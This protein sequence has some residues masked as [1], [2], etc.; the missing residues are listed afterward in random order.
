MDAV[1]R[2]QWEIAELEALVE[3]YRGASDEETLRALKLARIQIQHRRD[4]LAS[5][6]DVPAMPATASVS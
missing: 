1:T 2:L 5:W 4:K 6:L 3:K